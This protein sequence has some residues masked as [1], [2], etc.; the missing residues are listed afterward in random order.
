MRIHLNMIA[1]TSHGSHHTGQA[2]LQHREGG[3]YVLASPHHVDPGVRCI[4]QRCLQGRG[5]AQQLPH[6]FPVLSALQQRNQEVPRS[7]T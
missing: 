4:H 3:S 7:C 5:L 2:A 1:Y 6:S